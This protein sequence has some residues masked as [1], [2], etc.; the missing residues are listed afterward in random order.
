MDEESLLDRLLGLLASG[1]LGLAEDELGLEGP[2]LG[3]LPLLADLLV[4][5]GVVVLEVGAEAFLFEGSPD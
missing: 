5:E 2:G 4:D 1:A 3:D